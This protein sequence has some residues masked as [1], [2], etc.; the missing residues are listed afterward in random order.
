[1]IGLSRA[2]AVAVPAALLLATV[3][4]AAMPTRAQAQADPQRGREVFERNCAMCHGSDAKGMMGMHPSL[5]GAVRRLSREG[6]EVTIRKGRNTTP[7]MP[8]F[9]RRL[10]DEQIEDVITY[11][12]T[13]PVGPRNFGPEGNGMIGEDGMMGRGRVM[14][15]WWSL[16]LLSGI[17]VFVLLGL[18]ALLFLFMW[19][20]RS[21]RSGS[22]SRAL[23][24]LRERYARGEIDHDEFEQRRETLE[25]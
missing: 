23:E 13:L 17:G 9:G 3:A 21:S 2:V 18:F 10:S 14:G 6:V 1:M 11:L 15:G 5:R 8:S 20:F 7:P 12:D 25:R 22:K 16:L 4:A 19:W 24:I